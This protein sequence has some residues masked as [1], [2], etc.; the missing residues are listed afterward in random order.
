MQI[1]RNTVNQCIM[2]QTLKI[3]QAMS[4]LYAVF[5]EN[6][7]VLKEDWTSFNISI[8]LAGDKVAIRNLVDVKFAEQ[9]IGV[10]QYR[11]LQ[12]CG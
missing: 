10:I 4:Y 7:V 5:R 9:A 12:M 11:S 6:P 2:Q 8:G 1:L 3:E